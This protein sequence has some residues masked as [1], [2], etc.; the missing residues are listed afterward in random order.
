MLLK[1]TMLKKTI[2]LIM[3]LLLFSQFLPAADTASYDFS[4]KTTKNAVIRSV[5]FPGWG[6]F[7]IKRTTKGYVIMIGALVSAA[8]AYYYYTEANKS[9]DTY[10]NIGLISD[11][12][13]NDY[14]NKWNNSQY[15]LTALALFWVY[16]V[17]DL[18]LVPNDQAKN[19]A[20]SLIN[21]KD[22]VKLAF[23]KRDMRLVFNK[24][25]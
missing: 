11:G 5:I 1:E 4:E 18:L 9:Y 16:G 21:K 13:Y 19:E 20:T 24:T 2:A 14:Q 6:Q 23:D 17:V 3:C 8:A 12:S 10:K 25:F 22:G 7:F 15:A